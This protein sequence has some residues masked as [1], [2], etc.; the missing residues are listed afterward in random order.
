MMSPRCR[1]STPIGIRYDDVFRILSR[2]PLSES[3][4]L[5]VRGQRTTN[6]SRHDSSRQHISLSRLSSLS[7][8]HYLVVSEAVRF[9]GNMM[10]PALC[11]LRS[12]GDPVHP[13]G[14]LRSL[15]PSGMNHL[16]SLEL[17]VRNLSSCTLLA[18]LADTSS[19]KHCT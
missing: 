1:T 2:G 9:F 11:L 7:T 8:S 17:D 4:S 19:W 12:H 13:H 5:M 3:C 10:F 6:A 14:P 15:F 16:E 18:A